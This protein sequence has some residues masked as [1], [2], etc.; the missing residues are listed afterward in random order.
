[1]KRVLIVAML[2][3]SGC[4]QYD[5]IRSVPEPE[6]KV[7]QV[8]NFTRHQTPHKIRYYVD[9]FYTKSGVHCISIH[10]EALSC[11]FSNSKPQ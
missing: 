2:F 3:L 8:V 9:E 1:M 4:N 11:D 6:E 10:D 5:P 7:D